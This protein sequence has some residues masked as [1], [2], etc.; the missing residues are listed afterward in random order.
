MSRC[1]AAATAQLRCTLLHRNLVSPA[2]LQDRSRSRL[3][4]K[5]L[6]IEC[7]WTG[8][9]KPKSD[10][11]DAFD[12]GR[13]QTMERDGIKGM[14]WTGRALCSVSSMLCPCIA[15]PSVQRGYQVA[16]W[17]V[18]DP[19]RGKRNVMTCVLLHQHSINKLRQSLIVSWSDCCS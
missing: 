9:A 2:S 8:Q 3:A 7:I 6:G 11:S 17:Y 16:N 14:R 12:G 18:E 19:H 10:L 13:Q 5:P 15:S 1:R 4:W